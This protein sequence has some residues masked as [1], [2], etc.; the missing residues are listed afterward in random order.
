M[1]RIRM[2]ARPKAAPAEAELI[3][4]EEVAHLLHCSVTT[5]YRLASAGKLPGF[6]AGNRWRFDRQRVEDCMYSESEREWQKQQ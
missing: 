2:R 5:S 3:R 6:K 4:L 1:A